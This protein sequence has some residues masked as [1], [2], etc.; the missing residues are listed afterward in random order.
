MAMPLL[1][2]IQLPAAVVAVHSQYLPGIFV[3]IQRAPAVY[4]ARTRLE[5]R[6]DDPDTMQL[7]PGQILVDV[8]S[9]FR[10]SAYLS[11]APFS[12]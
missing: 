3:D 8:G 7:I 6:V 5:C 11:P 9:F 12:L 2:A 1:H 4:V 10:M